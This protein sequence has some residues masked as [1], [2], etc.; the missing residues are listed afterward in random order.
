MNTDYITN[1]I[2]RVWES[3]WSG[4]IS[5]ALE[6]IEQITYQLFL[7]RPDDMHTRGEQAQ[8]INHELLD[9]LV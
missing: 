5:N 6:L 4:G 8:S 3:F 1:Q 9:S 7:R 2:D